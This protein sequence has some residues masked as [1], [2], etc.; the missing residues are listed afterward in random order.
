MS[1]FLKLYESG[2]FYD[3]TDMIDKFLSG[4][5]RDVLCEARET[6][7]STF[8]ST[9]AYYLDRRYDYADMFSTLKVSNSNHFREYLNQCIVIHLDFSDFACTNYADAIAYFRKKMSD[10]YKIQFDLVKADER[11]IGIIEETEPETYLSSS[12]YYLLTD[13]YFQQNK[14]PVALLIDNLVL[15]EKFAY[16]YRYDE[17]MKEFLRDYCIEDIYHFCEIFLMVGDL[18]S[19]RG[20]ESLPN[21]WWGNRRYQSYFGFDVLPDSIHSD[22]RKKYI[23]PVDRQYPIDDG[24]GCPDP[25]LCRD[26]EQILLESH[27]KLEYE[28]EQQRIRDKERAE[29]ERLRYK[30]N[31]G[32]D[33]PKFSRNLGVRHF[34]MNKDSEGYRRITAYLENL[35]DQHFKRDSEIYEY[36]QQIKT[37]EPTDMKK[38]SSYY[39][40]QYFERS[41][42]G[43]WDK[44]WNNDD[45]YWNYFFFYK[46][47]NNQSSF[48]NSIKLYLSLNSTEVAE[49]FISLTEY[50]INHLQ[51]DFAIKVSRY[52]R[53]E[54][55]CIWVEP[56]DYRTA[57][58]YLTPLEGELQT[59]NPC[60]VYDHGVGIGRDLGRDISYNYVLSR[61]M[62]EYFKTIDGR[63]AISPEDMFNMFVKGWNRELDET[64]P[65][66][67]EFKY[68]TAKSLILVLDTMDVLCNDIALGNTT[69]LLDDK[70]FWD[71]LEDSCCWADLNEAYMKMKTKN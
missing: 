15:V 22:C 2:H 16:E 45:S 13:L 40:Y 6:G 38:K 12:L 17:K 64:C 55:I 69:L 49:I 7:M 32:E 23:V 71:C 68:F 46:D 61:I 31:L 62:F 21:T 29:A 27:R 11:F 34:K 59:D 36:Y 66:Q 19:E 58:S 42:E 70:Q 63:E 60:M 33:I 5:R 26:W 9:L 51:H 53:L 52:N 48:N 28:K 43:K 20:K 57:Q 18:P 41:A 47:K 24:D 35:Y 1:N 10:A 8:L 14:I 4:S 37:D 3:N 25:M 50:L 56:T 65:F 30:E 44:I 67:E 54:H 39:R